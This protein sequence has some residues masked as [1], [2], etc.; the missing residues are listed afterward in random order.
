MCG[1]AG[2]FSRD[3]RPVDVG[4][5]VAMTRTLEHRGP[6]E[7]GYFVNRNAPVGPDVPLRGLAGRDGDG[8]VGLGHRRLSI[9]DLKSGQQPLSNEDGRV[10]ISFNGEIYNFPELKAELEAAGHTFKTNSDTE[11]I[12]HGWEE[13]G[14]SLAPRLRGMFALAIWDERK[15]VLFLSRDR[16]GK[17]P[18]YYAESEGRFLFG[19]EIK[20]ILAAPGVSREIDP[21]A[22]S[23]YLSLLYVPAPKSI[24]KAVRKLPAG[25]SAVVTT[26]DVRIAPYWD[27]K[28]SPQTDRGVDELGEEI[29]E[30]L[31][32]A[33]KIR[34]MSEVPLGAFLSG[35]VDSSAVVG[36]MAA[37]R[38]AR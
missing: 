38:T 31:R 37:C 19:S 14:E 18:L 2:Y 26:D 21:T 12:V 4:V 23:D 6:D 29:V 10:W 5:L 32:E 1:I 24:F 9:I 8:Y 7:E 28:F 34:M 17:K 13:W 30:K 3:R 36:L 27:L 11:T 35:G 15:Q 25:Y 16:L 22:L 20:A 33:V